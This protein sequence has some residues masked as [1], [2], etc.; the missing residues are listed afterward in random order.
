MRGPSW[1]R[2][3]V[4]IRALPATSRAH[5]AIYSERWDRTDALLAAIY[6]QLAVANWQRSGNK[7][8]QR[9]KPLPRPGVSEGKRYGSKSMSIEEWRT[10][11]ATR[12]EGGE[13]G[14]RARDRVRQHRPVS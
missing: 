7:R 13:H 11:R 12:F 14:H 4:L 9:P 5:E 2:L 1:R 8:A 10:R 6:D 3:G